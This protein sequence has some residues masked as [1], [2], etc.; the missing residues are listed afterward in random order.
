MSSALIIKKFNLLTIGIISLFL[1]GVIGFSVAGSDEADRDGVFI[2]VSHGL[3]NPHRVLMALNMAQKMSEDH[4]VLVYFDIKGIEVVLT[5][6]ENLQFKHFTPSQTAIA[7]LLKQGVIV[8]VCPGCLKAEDKTE[9][10]VMKGVSIASKDKFFS[11]T[12]GRILSLDY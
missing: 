10:D 9:K 12:K 3:D 2:H 1:I 8:C 5:D 6:S 7:A 4:D 11:F